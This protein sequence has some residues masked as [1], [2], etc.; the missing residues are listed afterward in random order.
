MAVDAQVSPLELSVSRS[1]RRDL[2]ATSRTPYSRKLEGIEIVS[3]TIE[4]TN[5][6]PTAMTGVTLRWA[7]LV[8]RRSPFSGDEG[9]EVSRGERTV[10]L[11]PGKQAACDTDPVELRVTTFA[12]ASGVRSR[13]GDRIEGCVVEALQRGKVIASLARPQ[14]A[15]SRLNEINRYNP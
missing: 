5:R 13:E 12:S 14:E 11:A 15:K 2:K 7:V 3:Y 4:A 6:S 1:I 8:H 10:D 9:T